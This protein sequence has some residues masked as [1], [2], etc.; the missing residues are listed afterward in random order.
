M[1]YILSGRKIPSI[2]DGA[3]AHSVN[4]RSFTVDEGNKIFFAE[5]GVLYPEQFMKAPSSIITILS[6]PVKPERL[7]QPAKAYIPTETTPLKSMFVSDELKE[8]YR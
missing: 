2:G 7:E 5:D 1:A 3:F 6:S 4:L 8:L